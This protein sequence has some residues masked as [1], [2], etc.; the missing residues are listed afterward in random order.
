MNLDGNFRTID[1]AAP[2][3][4]YIGGKRMLAKRLCARIQAMPHKLYAEPFAGMG[5]VFFRRTSAP[6]GEVLNDRSTDVINLFR[7][8]QRHYPQFMEVLK[9]QIT[10]RKEFDRLKASDPAT[11][12]D[13]ERAARFLYL[14]RISF[15]GKVQ[16]RTFGVDYD[17]GSRFNLNN[18]PSLLHDAHERLA[19]VVLENLDWTAFIDKYD[20]AGTLFYLDPPYFGT[21]GYYGKDLFHRDQFALL[22]SR[23]R[24]IKGQFILSINDVPQIRELF[25]GFDIEEVGV[26]YTAGGGKGTAARELIIAH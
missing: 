15:G 9:F 17:R 8:L 3:A 24:E 7:I 14:Q 5:G 21:E 4:G 6:K 10:S 19:G 23:L 20:R 16:G 18:L 12:T 2:V 13:L 1:P 22:A 25:T 26:N 11:L